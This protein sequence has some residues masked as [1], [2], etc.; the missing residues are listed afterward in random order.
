MLHGM[1]DT[2]KVV[3]ERR[4]DSPAAKIFDLL[5]NPQHHHEFDGS[6]MI[7]SDEKSQR[8]QKVGDVF[9]MN[10]HADHMGGDYKTD[11]HVTGLIEN[12][13]VS[14][15]T[16]PAGTEPKGWEWMYE[17][18][19]EGSDATL[20]RLTYDWSKV[21]DSELL[22]KVSFPLITK[23]QLEASLNQLAAAVS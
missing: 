17:L 15:Q 21:T 5:T 3:V 22:K 4:I 13:L 2:N 10:M 9:T 7:V 14:W 18:E 20:V 6:G 16:A 19:S 12:K 8:L 23:D 1:T 11:N